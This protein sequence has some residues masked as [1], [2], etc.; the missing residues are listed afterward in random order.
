MSIPV[1]AQSVDTASVRR[2]NRTGDY[3]DK[4]HTIAVDGSGNIFV[5]GLSTNSGTNRVCEN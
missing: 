3:D 5:T 4:T 2:Y 1:F